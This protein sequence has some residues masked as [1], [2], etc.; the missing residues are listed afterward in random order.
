MEVKT[1]LTLKDVS[2]F[3]KTLKDF[4][5]YFQRYK[6][7]TV[8]GAMAYLT[9]ENKAHVLAEKE[10]LFIIR[11][12]GDSGSIFNKKDFKPKALS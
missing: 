4:K 11:A 7:E 2:D 12:T 6:S 5:N 9:S 1:A 8:Y 10:G 3:L